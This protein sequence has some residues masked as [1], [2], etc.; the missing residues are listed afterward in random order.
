[1]PD[2]PSKKNK[3][4]HKAKKAQRR[5][6]RWPKVLLFLLLLLT[7]FIGVAQGPLLRSYLEKEIQQQLRTAG[8]EGSFRVEGSLFSGIELRDVRLTSKG[9]IRELNVASLTVDYRLTEAIRGNYDKVL[10]GIRGDRIEIWIDLAATA[11]SSTTTP[12]TD[13]TTTASSS[14]PATPINL[15]TIRSYVLPVECFINRSAVRI[16]RGPDLIWQAQD[17]A[18]THRTGDEIFHL[19]LGEFTDMD[20]RILSHKEVSLTWSKRKLELQNFP[21]R[22]DTMLDQVISSW[23]D[24]WHPYIPQFLQADITWEGGLF[25][26]NLDKLEAVRISLNKGAIHLDKLAQWIETSD[27]VAGDITSL[28]LSIKDIM[29]PPNQF[30]S[31]LRIEAEHLQWQKKMIRN[32]ASDIST[33]EGS[34]TINASTRIDREQAS[35]L[36]ATVN[37][38]PPME[39]TNEPAAAWLNCWHN[40]SA[41]VELQIPEPEHIAASITGWF[42]DQSSLQAPPGGWPTGAI[43]L[44]GN[45]TVKDQ[46]LEQAKASLLYHAPAWSDIQADQILMHASWNPETQRAEGSL[47]IPNLMGSH[48]QASA[49][50]SLDDEHYDGKLSI[51]SLDLS[52][53]RSTL[54]R[55]NQSVPRAGLIQ[56]NWSGEGKVSDLDSYQGTITA[57]IEGLEIEAEGQPATDIQLNGQYAPGMQIELSKLLVTRDKL[58]IKTAANW[59]NETLQLTTLELHDQD[60]LLVQ[61]SAQLPLAREWSGIEAFLRQPGKLE[62][63][64]KIDEMPLAEIYEQLPQNS[65]P[66]VK[67]K[68][69]VDFTLGGTLLTPSIQLSTKAKRLQLI[70]N[71]KIPVTDINLEISTKEDAIHLDGSAVPDGHKALELAGNMPF[72]PKQWIDDPESLGNEAINLS[73]DTRSIDLSAFTSML[74]HISEIN[75]TFSSIVKLT[76]TIA[77]PEVQGDARLQISRVNSTRE[78]IPNLRDIDIRL[79]YD[80]NKLIIAPSSCL[81][82]GG[83]YNLSGNV[84][85]QEFSNPVFDI[86]LQADKALLWRDDAIIARSDASLKLNGP[87]EKANLSGDIGIVQSLFYKDVQIIPIGSGANRGASQ[88]SKAELPAFV[89]PDKKKGDRLNIPEPFNA[90]TL[91]LTAKTKEDFLIRGN[92]AKGNIKGNLVVT[93]TL[94]NPQ[95]KGELVL[96]DA[97]ASL[98]FSRLHV[99]EGKVFLTPKHGFDP[100][101]SLKATS[102]IGSYDV[103]INL[104]GLASNPKTLMTSRP[105]L[106]ESEIIL[107]LATG[108]TSEQLSDGASATGK[109]YQLLVDSVIRSS[110]GRF[111]KIMNTLAELNEKVDINIGASDPFTGRKYNSARVDITDR[112]HVVASID[113]DNN[114]RGMVVYAIQF[115]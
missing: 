20:Y 48:I 3:A 47:N 99:K 12:S 104:Y 21:I 100:Q 58:K 28:D 56:I 86:T 6:R 96:K 71:D 32:F 88:R 29:A 84:D 74:P 44:Q 8:I 92:I 83:K 35:Q 42:E 49:N 101:L 15:E 70:G 114:T 57:D 106:P 112:W 73:L 52:K 115:K 55:F 77:A 82:A 51:Q 68:L 1:M 63:Q 11:D 91:N 67:G 72:H 24:E 98:P 39:E 66:L 17:V 80:Q 90:W 37:I 85:F 97:Q 18:L 25:R 7:L 19:N 69:S 14:D 76:G 10:T 9:I 79:N 95:P 4:K 108:S 36:T 94:G 65:E 59:K 113:L 75:G 103:E 110:P 13:E 62:L 111:K 26:V 102:R 109:A 78:S 105:P 31:R 43:T 23:N 64:L 33:K 93:G 30:E 107:L 87:L 81:V 53:F 38:S 40:S 45:A 41:K 60:A 50:Y 27:D 46:E 2:S 61:G 22:Q 89:Q 54:E 34:A 16:S 5:P